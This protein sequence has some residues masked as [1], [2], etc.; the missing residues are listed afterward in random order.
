MKFFNMSKM[1]AWTPEDWCVWASESVRS[2]ET[3]NVDEPV[4]RVCAEEGVQLTL[5]QK[6]RLLAKLVLEEV[7]LQATLSYQTETQSLGP[8]PLL[9]EGALTLNAVRLE[10]RDWADES[11]RQIDPEGQL[12]A[13]NPCLFDK[14]FPR[15]QDGSHVSVV[16]R[17]EKPLYYM[18]PVEGTAVPLLAV[19]GTTNN[20]DDL[21]QIESLF[22]SPRIKAWDTAVINRVQT[23][24]SKVLRVDPHFLEPGSSVFVSLPQGKPPWNFVAS[25]E[26]GEAVFRVDDRTWRSTRIERW[27]SST[28]LVLV[29]LEQSS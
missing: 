21:R 11:M 9:D 29:T 12:L 6:I 22:V 13:E 25:V 17:G 28:E 1:R 15:I 10:V 27:P 4:F 23:S 18:N 24:L 7:P 3:L 16:V 2:T 14:T 26:A 5:P 20:S 8:E 19:G